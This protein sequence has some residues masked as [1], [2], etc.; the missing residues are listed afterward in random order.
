MS[1][2]RDDVCKE[3]VAIMEQ[4]EQQMSA[5]NFGTPGGLE[6][7]GDVWTLLSCWA[8]MIKAE[9][10]EDICGLCGEPSAPLDR[11]IPRPP[12]DHVAPEGVK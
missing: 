12:A 2:G 6:H 7:M 3:I 4:Y 9:E 10:G 8:Q 11:E 1:K 5:G